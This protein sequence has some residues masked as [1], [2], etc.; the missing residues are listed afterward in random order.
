MK[1]H[2]NALSLEDIKSQVELARLVLLETEN[3]IYTSCADAEMY[4]SSLQSDIH[5]ASSHFRELVQGFVENIHEMR[6]NVVEL[7]E[8]CRNRQ[9]QTVK[10]PSLEAH[11]IPKHEN[12]Y[13]LLHQIR[14]E[15]AETNGRLNTINACINKILNM[16]DCPVRAEDLVIIDKWSAICST[17]GSDFSAEFVAPELSLD[18]SSST[19][20]YDPPGEITEQ[21]LDREFGGGSIL[22]TDDQESEKLEGLVKSSIHEEAIILCL[23]KELKKANDAFNKLNVQLAALFHEKEIRNYRESLG[24]VNINEQQIC[25]NGLNQH[26]TLELTPV[27]QPSELILREAE[28]DYCNMREASSFFTKLEEAG[29]TMKE[30][31]VM[32]NALLKANESAKQLTGMWKQTGEE[33]MTE[34]ASLINEI[35]RLHLLIRLKDGQN[36]MLLD[37]IHYSLQETADSISLLE[38]SFLPMETDVDEMFKVI[39][40]DALT[41]AQDILNCFCKSRSSLEDIFR[42]TM[43]QGFA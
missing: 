12:Q 43:E 17:L 19:C 33:L 4:I 20:C 7:K 38:G 37:Q 29:A 15:L 40:G 30:A 21:T 5:E 36:E 3:D 14:D 18:G 2:G 41:M 27:L 16:Y 11:E 26:K 39:Y 8:N 31:D 22:S 42:E 32:L 28:A 24:F 25:R 6:K 9:V 23:R 10:I 34:K 35:E 1:V 13:F